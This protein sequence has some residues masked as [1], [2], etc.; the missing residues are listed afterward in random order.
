MAGKLAAGEVLAA[1]AGEVSRRE[2]V[3]RDVPLGDVVCDV[4]EPDP[5]GVFAS[6]DTETARCGE[7]AWKR[8]EQPGRVRLALA[9]PTQRVEQYPTPVVRRL[10]QLVGTRS[11]ADLE[12]RGPRQRRRP[13]PRGTGH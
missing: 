7:A 10:R 4:F 6:L 12:H 9:V 8:L 5:C 3:T 2:R 11:S 1:E 13:R